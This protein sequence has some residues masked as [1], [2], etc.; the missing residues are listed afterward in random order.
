MDTLSLTAARIY[1]APAAFLPSQPAIPDPQ[2]GRDDMPLCRHGQPSQ[3]AT[4]P[5]G[6]HLSSPGREP[7]VSDEPQSR[8]SPSS[9][10]DVASPP[11]QP[12]PSGHR[13]GPLT[14]WSAATPVTRQLAVF[15]SFI[16]RREVTSLSVRLSRR[17][18]GGQG[19]SPALTADRQRLTT[20]RP[21]R[22][23]F[24]PRRRRSRGAHDIADSCGSSPA[25]FRDRAA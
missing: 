8:R 25:A 20:R 10:H 5:K 2:P 19:R 6:G 7:A 14:P 13:A 4:P 1:R 21:N 9:G 12:M 22:A 16:R 3:P 11:G 24:G 23:P 17:Q 15:C 18:H